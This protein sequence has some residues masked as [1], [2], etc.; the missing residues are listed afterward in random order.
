MRYNHW[1]TGRGL[2]IAIFPFFLL[3]LINLSKTEIQKQQNN[4]LIFT[5]INL[6]GLLVLGILLPLSHKAGLISLLVILASIL[7]AMLMPRNKYK[8]IVPTLSII[9]VIAAIALSPNRILPFPLGL[10][11]GFLYTSLTRFGWLLPLAAIGLLTTDNWLKNPHLHRLFPA[12]LISLPF[13]CSRE[14]YGALI[15]LIFIVLAATNG[16][17]CLTEKYPSQRKLLTKTTIIMIIISALAIIIQRS[18]TATPRRVRDAALFLEQYDPNGPFQITSNNWRTKIQGYVS[19]CP[20]FKI[21][22]TGPVKVTIHNPPSIKGS[23]AQ[24]LANWT[25]YSRHIISVSGLSVLY[26]GKNPRRYIFYIDKTIPPPIGTI[27]IY[28]NNGIQIFKP[29][30][31]YIHSNNITEPLPVKITTKEEGRK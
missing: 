10:P 4:R 5:I 14:M 8:W 30:K 26:Y 12:L 24:V 25:S 9:A 2:F 22:K 17:I 6:L 23:P 29:I 18:I 11:V 15:A 19:G 13:S 7:P 3:T 28:N 31:Q 21:N 1:A 16:F 27:S 20:R